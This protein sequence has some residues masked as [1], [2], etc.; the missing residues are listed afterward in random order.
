ME[1]VMDTRVSVNTYPALFRSADT[2][3]NNKQKLYLALLR[4]EY[5]T[6]LLASILSSSLFSDPSFFLL[7]VVIFLTM[8]GETFLF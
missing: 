1:V 6:L 5:A 3:A 2:A 7:Y 4:A 8:P